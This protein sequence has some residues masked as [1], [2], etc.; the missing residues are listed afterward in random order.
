MISAPA[1]AE[2][3]TKAVKNVEVDALDDF[4]T[5]VDLVAKS[6]FDKAEE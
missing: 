3:T 4:E 5:S 2:F 6:E 1:I